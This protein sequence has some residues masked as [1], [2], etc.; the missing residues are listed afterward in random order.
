MRIL[1]VPR[2]FPSEDQPQSGIFVL[3][4]ALALRRLGHEIEVLRMVPFAPPLGRRWRAYRKIPATYAQDGITVRAVRTLVPPQMRGIDFVRAQFAVHLRREMAR[5]QPDLVHAHCTLPTGA[6]CSEIAAPVLLTAHGSDTYAEPWWRAGLQAAARSAVLRASAVVAVGEFVCGSV[7]ILG[8]DDAAVIF[9]GADDE[10]FFPKASFLARA[11]LGIERGRMVVVFAGNLCRAKGI[12]DLDESLAK[13][14]A[15]Q[16]LPLIAGLAVLPLIGLALNGTSS[17][18]Y[19]TV[20]ELV[21]PEKRQRAFSIFY[22]GG[23]GAGALAPV[24]YGLC[25]DLLDVPKM[26][27][28]IAAVVLVTLPLTW[29]LRPALRAIAA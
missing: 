28:L 20:P 3:R 27:V 7:Q 1:V 9:N 22:T 12:Y 2:D 19:G 5:F 17:V 6:L 16:P 14:G 29:R 13:I 26:M 10:V 18:L 23:I 24:L 8:R 21:A 25:S 11:Q 4:Q 15:L